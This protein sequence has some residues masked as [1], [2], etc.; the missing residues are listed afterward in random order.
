MPIIGRDFNP[1]AH[2][3][4]YY[5]KKTIEEQFPGLWNPVEACLSVTALL[6]LKEVSNCFMLVF[7]GAPSSRKTTVLNWFEDLTFTYLSD[8]FTP[9]SFVSH[10]AG[11]TEEKLSKNVDLLPRIKGKVLLTPELLPIFKAPA[12]TLTRNLGI[13]VRV[14]DGQGYSSDSGVYG[15]RG[16]KG[17]YI[18]HWLGCIAV[19]PHHIWNI[20]GNMGPRI[21]FY[22]FPKE[23]KKDAAELAKELMENYKIKT[24]TCK[25][26]VHSFLKFLWNSNN[27]RIEKWE[28][29]RDHP[30][31]CE[32]I[33][34]F[35]MLLCRLRGSIEIQHIQED[36]EDLKFTYKQPVIEEPHRANQVLYNLARG[37]AITLGRRYITKEDIPLIA[38]TAL[39]S[40]NTDRAKLFQILIEN[41][42][43]ATTKQFADKLNCSVTMALQTMTT[44]EILGLIDIS[45]NSS[46]KQGGRPMKTAVLKPEFQW[47]LKKE[48]SRIF[49]N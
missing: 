26:A 34:N 33:A 32:D 31:A 25:K 49:K 37:H 11:S 36:G 30:S 4:L 6:L 41:N 22:A 44:L 48:F 39:D 19:V 21:Y 1:G 3:K 18:F 46:G 47:V 12:E 14:L 15:H 35:A 27:S 17:D 10:Y 7:V 28:K 38:K 5:L 2:E 42:G 24:S 16:Y 23:A 20:L 8:D 29:E 40:A 45:E 43:T 13:I 9:S